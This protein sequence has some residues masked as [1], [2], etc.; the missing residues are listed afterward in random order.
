M[1]IKHLWIAKSVCFSFVFC[2]S[3]Q[4]PVNDSLHIHSLPSVQVHEREDKCGRV[5]GFPIIDI[6]DIIMHQQHNI[7]FFSWFSFSLHNICKCMFYVYVH[8]NKTEIV[9]VSKISENINFSWHV[10][11]KWNHWKNIRANVAFIQ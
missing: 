2:D 6:N 10:K 4:K 11:L 1:N 5:N 8:E 3:C 9:L 7:V